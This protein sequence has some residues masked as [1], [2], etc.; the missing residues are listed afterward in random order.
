[1]EGTACPC[2]GDMF[3][4]AV[5]GLQPWQFSTF[6]AVCL[7]FILP[8]AA[9]PPPK[10]KEAGGSPGTGG[11]GAGNPW[12][13]LDPQHRC[14]ATLGLVPVPS[15]VL[16]GSSQGSP[17]LGTERHSTAPGTGAFPAGHGIPGASQGRLRPRV[18]F[19]G[20]EGRGGSAALSP[21]LP[22][23]GPRALPHAPRGWG[24]WGAR[25]RGRSGVR[26]KRQELNSH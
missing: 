7:S 5:K 20:A 25:S 10:G 21:P 26:G 22:A 17:R 4:G 3:G 14:G 15:A 11:V 9:D 6:S 18:V 24:Q 16:R 23:R 12:L 13:S 8:G 19:A 1:M 2:T